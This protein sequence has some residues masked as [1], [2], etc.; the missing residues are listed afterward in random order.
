M[1]RR[2]LRSLRPLRFSSGFIGIIRGTCRRLEDAFTVSLLD[3]ENHEE[4]TAAPNGLACPRPTCDGKEIGDNIDRW[5]LQ[6][7]RS[8]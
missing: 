1:G 8:L 7:M 3:V 2:L 4:A 5:L 6:G